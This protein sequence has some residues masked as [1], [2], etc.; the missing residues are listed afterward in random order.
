[1]SLLLQ[2]LLQP[3]LL[4]VWGGS[5]LQPAYAD[6]ALFNA[7]NLSWSSAA[8][9]LQARSWSGF[10]A[11]GNARACAVGGMSLVPFFD[12]MGSVEMCESAA[13][14]FAFKT[15]S[16]PPPPPPFCCSYSL[17][18][19]SWSSLPS[20]PS[21]QGFGASAECQGTLWAPPSCSTAAQ[22]RVMLPARRRAGSVLSNICSGDSFTRAGNSRMRRY[23]VGGAPN[24]TRAYSLLL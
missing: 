15:S 18:S 24:G 4:L 14:S 5:N 7:T 1:M 9:L 6:A 10:A 12:P 2:V 17:E 3:S 22:C 20:L 8:P 23:F 21:A 13:A 19:K 16:E 11:C